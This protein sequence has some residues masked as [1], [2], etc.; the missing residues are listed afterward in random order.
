MEVSQNKLTSICTLETSINH[1]FSITG[2]DFDKESTH[3]MLCNSNWFSEC[4]YTSSL[5][6]KYSPVAMASLGN[7][8]IWKHYFYQGWN[9]LH[10]Q[11]LFSFHRLQLLL[12]HVLSLLSSYKF[13]CCKIQVLIL[14]SISTVYIEIRTFDL[15]MI[16]ILAKIN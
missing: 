5:C 4:I 10:S 16:T 13:F 14:L 8:T 7:S 6:T 2:N 9:S 1:K 11:K 12:I 3:K 15:K